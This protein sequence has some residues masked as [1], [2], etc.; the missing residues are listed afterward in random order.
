MAGS[1][2]RSVSID[3]A[4]DFLV[5]STENILVTGTV[6]VVDNLPLA[7]FNVG[8]ELG[9]RSDTAEVVILDNDG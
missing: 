6:P 3:V 1:V 5:E 9:D 7:L 8:G 2:T 4:D